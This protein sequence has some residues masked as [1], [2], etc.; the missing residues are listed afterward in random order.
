MLI[1]FLLFVP[2]YQGNSYFFPL[3]AC[4]VWKDSCFLFHN[5]NPN[6]LKQDASCLDVI[7]PSHFV[8]IVVSIPRSK[9]SLDNFVWSAALAVTQIAQPQ[10]TLCASL[11]DEDGHA[12]LEENFSQSEMGERSQLF[13][14][15]CQ[16]LPC[17]L[18]PLK[19]PT[20]V[21]KI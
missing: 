10:P 16:A 3:R 8:A 15:S 13:P 9:A 1:H 14:M 7:I 4:C 2:I 18:K 5:S 20:W 11:T 6:N 21:D 19:E 17:Q 12:V